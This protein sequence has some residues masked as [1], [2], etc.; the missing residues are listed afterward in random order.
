MIDV[1]DTTPEVRPMPDPFTPSAPSPAPAP[2]AAV[3]AP[4][5][6]APT[7]I[8]APAPVPAPVPV[9]TT[10]VGATAPA[11]AT[12]PV[13]A[14]PSPNPADDAAARLAQSQAELARLNA[15]L[16]QN[17][18]YIQLGQQAAAAKFNQPNAT[19]AAPQAVASPFGVPAFDPS[20]RQFVGQNEDGSLFE[21]PGAPLGTLAAYQAHYGQLPIAISKFF[22]DP[23]SMLAPVIE[24]LVEERAAKIVDER[25]GKFNNEQRTNQILG[26]VEKWAIQRDAAGQIVQEFD[27]NTGQYVP[28]LTPLGQLYSQMSHHAFRHGMR[29][30]QGIHDYAMAQVQLAQSKMPANPAPAAAPAAPLPVGQHFAVPGQP[31][32]PQAPARVAPPGNVG[33]PVVPAGPVQQVPTRTLMRQA[34]QSIGMLPAAG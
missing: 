2:A 29:D 24:K 30:P 12:V 18:P 3:P 9:P 19:P 4:A 16:N 5:A 14:P 26:E 11:P 1:I 22:T 31:A 25:F 28:A 15:F 32:F 17:R 7:F 6:P 33:V 21:K 13:A 10:G 23:Q 8:P 27:V 34:A 20:L